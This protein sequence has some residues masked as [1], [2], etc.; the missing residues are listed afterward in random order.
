MVAAS[1][2]PA[3][4]GVSA[5]VVESPLQLLGALEAHAAGLAGG[6]TQIRVRSGVPALDAA[7]RTLDAAGLPDGVE[8]HLGATARDVDDVPRGAWLVGDAFSGQWQ[9]AFVR[10]RAHGRVVLL[11]DGLATVTLARALVAGAPAVRASRRAGGLTG[12]ARYALGA[13]VTRRLRALAGAGRLTMFT[14]MPLDVPLTTALH[15]L[16]VDVV[17]H[18]F[19]WLAT[20]RPPLAP[21]EPT[22]VV[23][24]GL[25]ADGWVRADPYVAWVESLA[26]FGP[27]AYLPH[28]RCDPAVVARLAQLPG[29][30]VDEAGLPVEMR[31]RGLRPPQRVVCLPSTAYVLLDALHASTGVRIQ[32]RPV[33]DDWWTGTAAPDVR[34]HLS[35]V[36]ALRPATGRSRARAAS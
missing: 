20:Q 27:V 11:D 28:R 16:G 23:G 8:M 5:A 6:R 17:T 4:G 19:A 10:R 2:T 14:A 3:A 1:S 7:A 34:E 15:G 31:L 32:A 26:E 29:V 25:V 36:L 12:R 13:L 21:T 9:A 18:R 35:S 33:P 22:I 24:S 30:R